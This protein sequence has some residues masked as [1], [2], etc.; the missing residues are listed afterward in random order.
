MRQWGTETD[1]LCVV[2]RSRGKGETEKSQI[3]GGVSHVKVIREKTKLQRNGHCLRRPKLWNLVIF[4]EKPFWEV[5]KY[6]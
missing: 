1:F 6:D 2:G 3:R 4:C 5:S